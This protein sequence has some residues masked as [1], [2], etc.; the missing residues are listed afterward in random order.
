MV[1]W[2]EWYAITFAVISVVLSLVSLAYMIGIGFHLP[3]LQAWAKD[4]LYQAIGS[5]L[6][7]ILIITFVSIIDSSM[8]SIYGA[9][10]FDMAIDYITAIITSLT[11]FFTN[12][13]IMDALFG[14]LQSLALKAMPSQTGF[15]ISPFTGLSPLT[16]MLSLSMEAILGGMGLML[17]QISFLLFIK[18]QLSLLLPIGIALRAFPFSRPA[19]GAMIAVFLGFYVFYPF[20][21]VFNKA[22]YDETILPLTIAGGIRNLTNAFGVGTSCTENPMLCATNTPDFGGNMILTLINSIAYPVILHLFIF[23]VFLPLFN[24]I[25][26]LVLIN[27]LAKIFGGEID[28]G[29]LSGLI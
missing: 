28:I 24:L 22:M 26:V 17:G 21:W 6:L 5:A 19:G 25:V 29:G 15:N 1:S 18:N 8:V 11:L 7:A 12:V 10:P 2:T 13:V 3:K 4:E 9:D 20:L 23:V 27:E 14:I 16:A